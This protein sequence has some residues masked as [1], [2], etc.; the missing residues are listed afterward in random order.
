MRL[1][2]TAGGE[3][4]PLTGAPSASQCRVWNEGPGSVRLRY[5]A[6]ESKADDSDLIVPPG[7][8]ETHTKYNSTFLNAICKPGETAVIHA[9]AGSGD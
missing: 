9:I 6:S 8:I 7:L 5:T 1:V 4:V 3:F 2:V